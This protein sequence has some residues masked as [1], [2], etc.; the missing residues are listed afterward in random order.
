MHRDLSGLALVLTPHS[1]LACAE[2]VRR[3]GIVQDLWLRVPQCH[4]LLR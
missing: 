1:A 4:A 2:P 3:G